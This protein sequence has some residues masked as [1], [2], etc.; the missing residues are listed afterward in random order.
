M[1]TKNIQ[2]PLPQKRTSYFYCINIKNL[3]T[4]VDK[5]IT[6][7][8]QNC[9]CTCNCSFPFSQTRKLQQQQQNTTTTTTT[10]TKNSK[11]KS[12]S[13]T[14]VFEL[15]GSGECTCSCNCENNNNNQIVT[16][17]NNNELIFKYFKFKCCLCLCHN[18]EFY[19]KIIQLKSSTTLLDKCFIEE[20]NTFTKVVTSNNNNNN[21][22]DDED[23]EEDEEEDKRIYFNNL[24]NNE[25]IINDYKSELFLSIQQNN[26][27][28]KY[29]LCI[30]ELPLNKFNNFQFYKNNLS[31][32]PDGDRIDAIHADWYNNLNKLEYHHGYVQWLFPLYVNNGMN[33]QAYALTRIESKLFR[34]DIDIAKRIIKSY[35]LMLNFY[36]IRLVDKHT[37]QLERSKDLQHSKKQF[38]NLSNNSHNNLRISRIITFLGLVGFKRY[39]KPLVDFLK[40]HINNGNLSISKYSIKNYWEPLIDYSKSNSKWYFENT[41]ENDSDN[42]E[43]IYFHYINDIE[44]VEKQK[45]EDKDKTESVKEKFNINDDDDDYD[46]DYDDDDGTDIEDYSKKLFNDKYS[47][48]QNNYSLN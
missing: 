15:E 44:K 1:K 21:N 14:P 38:N 11:S 30:D 3:T 10:T 9:D 26:K 24:N 13:T 27:I 12:T 18:R 2:K 34:N 42:E 45:N 47:L 6:I 19:L 7:Y 22:E 43:S 46:Y 23:E 48:H 16:V 8:P 31:S 37:G 33:Y 20:Y 40:Y 17:K 29:H 36:G 25:F 4:N 32:K 5:I 39:K 35:E 41:L 28:I